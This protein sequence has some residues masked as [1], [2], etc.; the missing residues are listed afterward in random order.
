MRASHTWKKGLFTNLYLIYKNDKPIGNMENKTFSKS[1]K[2]SY[3]GKEYIFR[4]LGFFK[5]NTEIIDCSDNKVIGHIQYNNWMTKALI[6]IRGNRINWRSNNIWNTQWSL[7]DSDDT[8][9][10]FYGS[11]KKGKIESTLD[12]GVL[13]L[14]GL[15]LTNYYWQLTLAILIPLF[16]VI[17][18]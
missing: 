6:T 12:D 2:G 3:N 5:Q 4:T 7:Y 13:I 17:L 16:L 18:I 1:A 15:F 10:T 8:T 9:M 14:T 11:I